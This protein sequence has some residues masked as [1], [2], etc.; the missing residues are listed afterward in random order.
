MNHNTHIGRKFVLTDANPMAIGCFTH[1]FGE[2]LIDDLSRYD[3][4]YAK[5][6]D[7]VTSDWTR[8]EY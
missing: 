5:R 2:L 4:I 7:S 1:D 6:S 3:G 8:P